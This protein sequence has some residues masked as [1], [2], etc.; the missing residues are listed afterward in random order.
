MPSTE[1]FLKQW[2]VDMADLKKDKRHLYNSL[3]EKLKHDSKNVE[4]YWRL[5]EV[6]LALASS[7]IN[8]GDQAAGQK[9]TEEAV[10]YA[11]KAVEYG[12]NSLEAHK[13][14]AA[15]GRQTAYV[16]TKEKIQLGNEFKEHRDLAMAIDP[17]DVFLNHIYGRWCLEVASL[18]W[19]ERKAATAFFGEPPEA[20]FEEALASFMSVQKVRRDWK[21]NHCFIAKTY[22]AMKKYHEAM[23]WVDSGLALPV[24]SD[25][26]GLMETDLKE[27]E[28]SYASY[29]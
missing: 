23:K 27:M 15:V 24:Q 13:F 2:D 17:N 16:P 21:S 20:T 26:D 1:N 5:V 22:V 6:C 28:K 3:R 11:R 10:K 25:E 7:H 9:Y 14:C 12:P 4:L 29:R 8:D 19:V 18:T